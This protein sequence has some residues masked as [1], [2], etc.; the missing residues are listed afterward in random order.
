MVN[1][2]FMRVPGMGLTCGMRARHPGALPDEP[3]FARRE[4]WIE[5]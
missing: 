4:A 3:R 1:S 5:W 2:G